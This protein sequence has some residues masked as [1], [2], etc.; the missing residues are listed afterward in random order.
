M[1]KRITRKQMKHD[2]FVE[3]TFDFAHW[4]EQHWGK[5]ASWVAVAILAVLAV[6]AWNAM[7]RSRSEKAMERLAQSIDR[8]EVAQEQ[9]FADKE[10]LA[11]MLERF[12]EVA[13]SGGK[14]AGQVA[15]F[16]RGATLFHLDRLD[17]A[18]E[19]LERVVSR[20]GASVTV[21]ATAQMLLA[22]VEIAAGRTDEAVTLLQGLA[23]DPAAVVPPARALLELGRIQE[24]AGD[25]EQARLQWQRILDEYPQSV[26]A[27]EARSLLQ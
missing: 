13:S 18:R 6:L 11:S 15:R 23:D 12:E 17:E 3:A 2:E 4:L 26:S 1:A 14:G 25:S 20:S 10:E 22:R 5:V 24:Q 16:Y 19:D 7:A 9:G 8:Y 21:G 27:S